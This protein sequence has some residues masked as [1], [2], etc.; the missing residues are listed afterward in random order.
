MNLEE[1]RKYKPQIE[2]IAAKYGVSNI[3]VFGSVARGDAR[4]DSD[5]DIIAKFPPKTGFKIFGGFLRELED[6]LDTPVDLLSE[7][8]INPSLEKYIIDDIEPL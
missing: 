8:A 5:V 1:L 4:A 7:K 6:T 3:R 2:E